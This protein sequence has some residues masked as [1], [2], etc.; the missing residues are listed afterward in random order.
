MNICKYEHSRVGKHAF[1]ETTRSKVKIYL[2]ERLYK[3]VLYYSIYFWYVHCKKRLAI[4]LSQKLFPAGE[5]LVSGI[6]DGTGKSLTF[7]YS[8]QPRITSFHS[9]L[10]KTVSYTITQL[11]ALFLK[12]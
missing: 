2:G 10:I 11:H 3:Y 6:P 5:S 9:T 1:I 8:V 12:D 7:F 4:V